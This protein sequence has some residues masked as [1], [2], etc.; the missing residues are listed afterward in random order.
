MLLSLAL[1]TI[2]SFSQI[3]GHLCRELPETLGQHLRDVIVEYHVTPADGADDGVV[4]M[5]RK[6]S[7]RDDD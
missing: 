6:S 5:S 3:T 2:N 7:T 4:L 1:H